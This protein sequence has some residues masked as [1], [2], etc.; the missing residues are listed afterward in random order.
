MWLLWRYMCI[1][2]IIIYLLTV[3][4]MQV[5]Q[6]STTSADI[7]FALTMALSQEQL[8]PCQWRCLWWLDNKQADVSVVLSMFVI[9][10]NMLLLQVHHARGSA[11][12]ERHSDT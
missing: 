10:S 9:L 7:M 11:R 12:D 3:T 5:H 4:K 1:T 8:A 6:S 2:Y